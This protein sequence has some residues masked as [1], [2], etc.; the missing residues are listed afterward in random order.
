DPFAGR[1]F[2]TIERRLDILADELFSQ[3]VDSG[4]EREARDVNLSASG[5]A[6]NSDQ[7]LSEGTWLELE[8]ELPEKRVILQ[9]FALVV[10]CVPRPDEEGGE[11]KNTD[12][13]LVG[14]DMRFMNEPDQDILVAY[15][16]EEQARSIRAARERG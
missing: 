3:A 13:F 16:L 6:F 8:F 10:R 15:I 11:E 5:I 2:K 14:T 4:M 12:S 9:A 7:T 1:Y